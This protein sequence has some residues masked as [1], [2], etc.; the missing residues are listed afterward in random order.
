MYQMWILSVPVSWFLH[1]FTIFCQKERRRVFEANLVK[2][3]LELEIE[4]KSVR[5]SQWQHIIF[6]LCHNLGRIPKWKLETRFTCWNCH[7]NCLFARNLTIEKPTLWRSMLHGKYWQPMQMCW[8]SRFHSRPTTSQTTVRCP[9]T[10]CPL[11][12]VCQSPSCS[13]NQTFLPLPST[14]VNLISS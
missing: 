4:D 10:G 9:W 13:L 14:R 11:L 8:R 7:P 5:G 2:V 6:I 12:F 1:A 3:G